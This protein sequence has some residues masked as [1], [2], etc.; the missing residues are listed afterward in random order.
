MKENFSVTDLKE[1]MKRMDCDKDGKVNVHDFK[2]T[3][4]Q[5]KML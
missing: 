2:G 4:I 3:V 5:R 1:L